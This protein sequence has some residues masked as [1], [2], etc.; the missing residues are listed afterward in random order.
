MISVE[1]L[2]KSFGRQ[3]VLRG[4]SLAV[5]PGEFMALVGMSGCGKSVLLKHLVGLIEPDRGRVVMAQKEISSL[6]RRELD[7][8]RSRIGFVF[9]GG[10]LFDSLTVFENTAFPLRE[11]TRLREPA[12]RSKVMSVLEQVGLKNT[13][14]KY[15]AQLS[16]GMVKRVALARTLVRAPEIVL[17]DE[18]TTGLDP[19]VSNA[20]LRLFDE[21]HRRLKLTGI[22]VSH[23]IPEIFSI[24]QKVAMLHEGKIVAVETPERIQNSRNPIIAQFLSGSPEGPIEY[25]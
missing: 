24:V 13:E 17:F 12:I 14:N 15:P 1:D 6:S 23:E 9:Q 21:V 8:L 10:A 22:L 4:I 11:K 20:M 18:P 16:G 2:W 3:E 25:R 19:I 7:E 5:E